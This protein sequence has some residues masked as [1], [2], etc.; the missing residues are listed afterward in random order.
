MPTLRDLRKQ[1]KLTQAD[2]AFFASDE[3]EAGQST[4]SKMENGKLGTSRA[5]RSI[6][7]LLSLMTPEQRAAAR[8]LVPLVDVG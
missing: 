3:G 4:M 1:A 5:T 8:E 7:V 2:V 6:Y